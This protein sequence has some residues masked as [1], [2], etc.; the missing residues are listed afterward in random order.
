ME[1]VPVLGICAQSS[2]VGK[3]TLLSKLIPAL[4]AHGLRVSVIKQT[5]ENFDLDRPGKD[6]YR[7]RQ[8]GARQVL[9]SAPERW[10]L[11]TEQESDPDDQRLMPL[12]RHL[13]VRQL[14]L[15]LVEGFRHAPIPKIEV[16]RAT[17]I[18]PLLAW[19]D[20][21]VIAVASDIFL[22]APV[23][24]LDL[25]DV[26]AVTAYILQWMCLEQAETADEALFAT[27]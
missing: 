15:V 5:C 22:P 25:D 4:A 27:V 3:T 9:L 2:G 7:L 8:A 17:C 20:R 19:Q 21:H 16:F 14:D 23:P 1:S 12:I 10:V 11:M 24:L 6:S 26:V 13:D 18:Q